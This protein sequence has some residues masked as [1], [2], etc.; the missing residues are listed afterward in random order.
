MIGSDGKNMTDSRVKAGALL[1]LAG[2]GQK[3]LTPFEA[4]NFSFMSPEFSQKPSR[5]GCR[6]RPEPVH[7]VH[8]RADWWADDYKMSPGDKSLLTDGTAGTSTCG[9]SEWSQ[10]SPV[11]QII[12][13]INKQDVNLGGAGKFALRTAP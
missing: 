4:K 12:K 6:R 5:F 3:N 11:S 10:Y 8:S 13:K 1:A 2:L 7:A 9:T